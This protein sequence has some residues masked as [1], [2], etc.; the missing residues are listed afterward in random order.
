MRCPVSY[1][2]GAYVKYMYCV[3]TDVYGGEVTTTQI[4]HLDG[5]DDLHIEDVI[6]CVRFNVYI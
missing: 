6:P 1:T 3:D 4:F 2:P 5:I